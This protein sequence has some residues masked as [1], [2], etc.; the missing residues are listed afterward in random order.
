MKKKNIIKKESEFTEI[1]N[2]CPYKKNTYFVIY[3]RK[4]DEQNRYGITVP[5]KTGKANIR[6][7]IKRRVKNIIDQN[8]KIVHNSYDYVIII[9]KRLLELNYKQIE[10]NLM[11][12]MNKIG[13]KYEQK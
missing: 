3:Y 9:R 4:N 11:S 5:K 7:K 10:E 12:L 8:E 2:N 6:N 13:E 1:I